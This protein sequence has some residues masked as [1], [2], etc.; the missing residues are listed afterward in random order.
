[1]D[2]WCV[3]KRTHAVNS[4][5]SL[6]LVFSLLF[7][8]AHVS[9]HELDGGDGHLQDNCQICRMAHLQG[10]VASLVTMFTPLFIC[11]GIL[12]TIAVPSFLHGRIHPWHSRAPPAI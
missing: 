2:K 11:L 4:L 8:I 12:V 7:A 5:L 1:M 9:Q 10:A 3:N 6:F